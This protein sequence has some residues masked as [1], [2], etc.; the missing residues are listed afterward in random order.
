MGPL[1]LWIL[2]LAVSA[3]GS[4]SA[5][6]LEWA[7]TRISVEAAPEQESFEGVFAFTNTGDKTVTIDSVRSSCGCTVPALTKHEYAP[8]ESG[9]I[10][11]VF[12]FGTRTGPQRKTIAVMTDEQGAERVDL[13]LEVSIPSLIEVNPFFV[14]WRKGDSP[15]EAKTIEV[16]VS[17]PTLIAPV[18]VESPSESF[19]TE[20][21]PTD[22]P[23]VFQ[24]AITPLSTE[25]AG[26][27]HFLIKTNYPPN[28]PRVI[29]VYAGIR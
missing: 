13:V 8:G 3:L 5:S 24:L 12:T 29:R 14:F 19:A 15:I 11:A 22:D 27:T 9:E 18:S 2:T 25:T 21:R 6:A 10:K 7:T 26:N 1:R 17:D 28:N 23:A 16:R 4:L 20:L